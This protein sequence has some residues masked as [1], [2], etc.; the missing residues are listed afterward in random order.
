MSKY[1]PKL[2]QIDE[3]ISFL[4]GAIYS[5]D[6]KFVVKMID[7]SDLVIDR[8]KLS[9]YDLDTIFDKTKIAYVDKTTYWSEIYRSI[10]VQT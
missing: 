8:F 5:K 6:K 3:L 9:D 1:S 7:I 4:Y 2:Y 10:I